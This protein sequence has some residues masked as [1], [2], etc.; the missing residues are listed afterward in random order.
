M[1]SISEDPVADVARNPGVL[2]GPRRRLRHASLIAGSG[3]N[4]ND[5]T[6]EASDTQLN[7]GLTSARTQCPA[8]ETPIGYQLK[9]MP[10]RTSAPRPRTACL[11]S[12]RTLGPRHTAGQSSGPSP[13]PSGHPTGTRPASCAR[14]RRARSRG[15]GGPT[16]AGFVL[17]QGRM[18]GGSPGSGHVRKRAIFWRRV[19]ACNAV[20]GAPSL[21][22]QG[23]ESAT[24]RRTCRA[25]RGRTDRISWSWI[26]PGQRSGGSVEPTNSSNWADASDCLLGCSE[27]VQGVG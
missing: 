20:H 10:A 12:S 23:T 13:L 14:D 22:L 1:V 24:T 3:S 19:A 2:S 15:T 7:W 5:V 6:I 25:R 16:G 4:V 27:G 17:R 18:L 9:P 26:F 8:P 21:P 11:S